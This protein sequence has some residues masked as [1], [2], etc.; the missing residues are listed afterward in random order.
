METMIKEGKI[1]ESEAVALITTI[2]TTKVFI[3]MPTDYVSHGGS[4]AW[5]IVIISGLVTAALFWFS[6][7]FIER[8]PDKTFPETAEELAGPYF[9]SLIALLILVTWVFEMAMTLRR[10]SEMMVTVA[11]PETPISIIVLSFMAASGIAAYLG[12]T[13]I[14]RACYLSFPFSLGAILLMAVLT[15][16][17]WNTDWLFPLLGK[18][19]GELFKYGIA[20][21]GDYMEMN[22]LYALPVLFYSRQVRRISYKSIG[23]SMVI[24]LAVILT[25]SLSFPAVVGQEPFSGLYMMAR[26]VYLGRFLQRVE[27]IFVLFWVVGG[28]LWISAGLYGACAILAGL[29]RQP[30]YRPLVLPVAVMMAAIAF[31]PANLPDAV[32]I[33]DGIV[34]NWGVIPLFG[35]SALLL[36]IGFVRRKGGNAVEES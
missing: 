10:F 13:T 3:H 30:D 11:L 28:Y 2:V 33:S 8:F 4:A 15:Y 25:Y 9:G 5:V 36:L 24:F 18:G 14:A 21:S 17:L 34:R 12:V 16:P 23:I 27:A 22:F 7:K 6:V 31:I 32:L 1:G 35:L 29:L 26:N 20:N 19:T